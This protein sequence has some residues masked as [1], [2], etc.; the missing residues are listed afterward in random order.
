MKNGKYI[1][2]L[3]ESWYVMVQYYESNRTMNG[4]PVVVSEQI[5]SNNY[6]TEKGVAAWAHKHGYSLKGTIV[7]GKVRPVADKPAKKKTIKKR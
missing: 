7:N 2:K 1:K 4:A 5:M 6:K 3:G